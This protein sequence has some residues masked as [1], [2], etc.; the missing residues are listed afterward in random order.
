[1]NRT[2]RLLAIVLELQAKGRQRAVDLADLFETSTRT[3]YRDIQALSEAGVPLVAVPGQGYSLME[4]Y[5]L[6]PLTFTADEATMLLLGSDVAAQSFD[7]QYRA[8]A[9]TASR[10]IAGVLPEPL[11]VEVEAIRES[12]HFI[13][14]RGLLGDETLARL[15]RAIVDRS[16]VRFCYHTRHRSEG[17]PAPTQREVDPYALAHMAGAWYLTGYDHLRRAVRTF[18]LDRIEEVTV[19]DRTFV[20]PPG[21]FLH[22][23]ENDIRPVEIRALFT[24]EVARWVRESRSFYTVTEE[25]VP[26]GLLVTLQVRQESEILSWLLGWGRHV[27]VLAPESLRRQIAEEAEAL[28]ATHRGGNESADKPD[29]GIAPT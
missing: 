1:M 11:R 29:N 28:L 25:E 16:A 9:Q 23:R 19:L 15:R 8:A 17:T 13:A 2:D 18:R 4:G 12:I 5:F 27:R 20:R 6:P 14:G 24:P 26:E 7:A 3:I 22:R 10:K 21:A